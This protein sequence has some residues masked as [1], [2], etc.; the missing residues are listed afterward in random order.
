MNKEQ[1]SLNIAILPDR[2]TQ[3]QA[4]LLSQKISDSY[5]TFFT[6]NETTL[7]PHITVYQAHFPQENIGKVNQAVEK[8]LRDYNSFVLNLQGVSVSHETFIFWDCAKIQILESLQKDV[9]E[10]V[11]MLR[12]GLVLPHLKNVTGLSREDNEDIKQYGALLIG[13]R[14]RPHIT[15]TRIKNSSDA[16]AALGVLT[17]QQSSR[18]QVSG[19]VTAYL[20]DHGTV[21]GVIK[22]IPLKHSKT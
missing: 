18:V 4:I 9:I 7:L 16:K 8:V 17:A 6:L 1:Q 19:I 21:N 12:N 3:Q 11:N 22:H 10:S 2:K 15:L 5:P 13:P 20:G 14:Y